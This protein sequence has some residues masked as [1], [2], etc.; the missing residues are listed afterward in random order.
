M[1]HHKAVSWPPLRAA[2]VLLLAVLP[3]SPAATAQRAP[4]SLSPS[5]TG[6]ELPGLIAAQHA[7]LTNGDPV[8]IEQTTRSLAALLLR[9]VARLKMRAGDSSEAPDLYRRSLDLES[10]ASTRMELA[11][12]LLRDGRAQDAANEAATI[13]DLDP[14]NLPALK[15]KGAAL[16]AAGDDA[17]AAAVYT[18]ALQQDQEPA[19]A[20]ALGSTFLSLHRK[21]D[22]DKI[23]KQIL[24]TS[25]DAA[26]WHAAIGDAYRQALYADE[27]I[28]QF[29]LA[30]ARDP[31][32]G[33][34][35]FFL[36]LTYLQQ[37]QWGPNPQS[38]LHLRIAARQAPHEYISNFY[39]GA[40]ES[41]AGQDLASSNRHLHIAAAANP[42]SPEVWI[43]LGLNAVRAKEVTEAK[44]YLRKAVAL[45][46]SNE[47]RNN[48]QIRRVYAILGR[49]LTSEGDHAEG[50]LLLAKYKDLSQKARAESAASIAEE[51]PQSAFASELASV[52]SPA[53]SVSIDG[54]AG[55]TDPLAAQAQIS[56]NSSSKETRE[57]ES[58]EHQLDGLLAS[59]LNDLGTVEARQ[60]KYELALHHFKEAERW[61]PP[62]P[63]LLRN[64]GMTA[65]RLENYK[66]SARAL[67]LYEGSAHTAAQ[68]DR[69]VVALAM[70]LFNLGDFPGAA[71]AFDSV[72]ATTLKDNRTAYSW[73]YSLAHSGKQQRAIQIADGLSNQALPSDVM[74][75]V[76]HLYMD[77][78]DYEQSV[79]CFRRAYQADSQLKLAH[80]QVAESLIR[81]D[82]PADAVTELRQERLLSP[83]NPDV[84]YSLAFALLQASQRVEAKTILQDLTVA[85]PEH[86]QAQYQFGKL[87]LEEGSPGEA[88]Q[89]LEQAEK[90][91]PTADY[92][93]YQLQAA[94]RK[95][96][97]ADDAN[98]ELK[99]YQDIKAQHRAIETPSH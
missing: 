4:D 49:I 72:S 74:S 15:L 43:Y 7:A 80:Y 81:L 21:Q 30:I 51:N 95:A 31:R 44:T 71:A 39:L 41:T 87:L 22:A 96:G 77:T 94:Y 37:N 98:R 42:A 67:Q 14:R 27:A 85:H 47:A 53:P 25:G 26:I 75:L 18:R 68:D 34:A 58:A 23:F 8:T 88:V 36:G 10:S 86:A 61:A 3:L 93:H 57:I 46:G 17:G 19:L 79:T 92:I 1:W 56:Q 78:E 83:D 59:S 52:A 32:A 20:Y 91:E 38:F 48:Y 65:F 54:A 64:L 2:F 90:G 82:R 28:A 89:H 70:S 40:L 45:T 97:R 9:L 5:R 35:E 62:T 99:L 33:H 66:E 63:V 13:V 29:K 12:T 76:C 69:P 84:Q 6:E 60:G 73:A 24:L 50:D 55:M 16:H 11:T